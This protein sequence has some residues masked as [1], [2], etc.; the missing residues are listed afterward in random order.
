MRRRGGG[1]SSCRPCCAGS[2]VGAPSP[3]TPG[4]VITW[5]LC[6]SLLCAFQSPT[7]PTSQAPRPVSHSQLEDRAVKAITA[8]T[9][10]LSWR[11]L[12]HL[13]SSAVPH[14]PFPWLPRLFQELGQVAS[15]LL[16]T[17]LPAAPVALSQPPEGTLPAAPL[18]R[19]IR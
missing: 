11:V 19:S 1:R 17:T 2:G 10:S 4:E 18:G 13:W 12:P 8:D 3:L 15:P 16:L 9:V 5:E 6:P 7:I 14:L